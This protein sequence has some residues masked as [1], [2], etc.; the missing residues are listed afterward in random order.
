MED[1]KFLDN[2]GSRSAFKVGLLSGIGIM[3][4]IGFFVVIGILMQT[5]TAANNNN[6]NTNTNTNPTNNGAGEIALQK[7]TKDD[8]L[9][10][11]KKADITIVEFSDLDCPYC[12]NFHGTMKQIME[13]YDGEVNWVY[14]NFPLTSLH[15]EAFK[16][17]E[18]AECVGELGGND[19]FWAFLDKMFAN[20][21]ALADLNGVIS[22]IGIDT[23][24]FQNCL[25][26]GKYTE[27]VKDHSSQA[28]AAGGRGTPYSIIIA[29]D[30]KIPINGALPFEQIAQQLD[31]LL[32]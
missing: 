14:R 9:Q 20:K 6:G 18:A 28:V 22:S 17:A 11:D 29:G 4:V 27:K 21:T 13:E 8:W 19:K 31:T 24:D 23:N 7:V 15:P 30:Q 12:S 1:K 25:D 5:K 26:S 16:K 32:K 3:F 2:L 10:G